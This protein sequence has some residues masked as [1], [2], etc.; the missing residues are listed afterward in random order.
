MSAS[1]TGILPLLNSEVVVVGEGK[2]G[3][4]FSTF[5]SMFE[6]SETVSST[7]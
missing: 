3:N 1:V 4:I 7:E 6:D 2:N 5:V